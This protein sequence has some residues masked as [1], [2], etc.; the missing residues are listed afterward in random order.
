MHSCYKIAAVHSESLREGPRRPLGS[1]PE[2]AEPD[3]GGSS[4]SPFE[5]IVVDAALEEVCRQL[6]A[7]T[8]QL[9]TDTYPAVDEL[10]QVCLFCDLR[11]SESM[12]LLCRTVLNRSQP[13]VNRI[14]ED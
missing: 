2:V 11:H 8:V 13:C 5:H 12:L 3:D 4:R 14:H 7:D 9:Q 10:L 1:A 6:A